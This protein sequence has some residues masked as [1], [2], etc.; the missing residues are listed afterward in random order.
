MN[1]V[2]DRDGKES[3]V[4]V[5]PEAVKADGKSIGRFGSYP[6]TEN[7]FLKV[8]SSSG[9]TVVSTAGL[10]LTN[11]QKIVTGQFS[12]DMLA[13]PVGIYDMTGEVAK[14]GVLTLMQFAAF[15]S[16]NLGIVNLLPIPALDGGR[17]LFLFV[18]AIR[19][20]PINREKEALVVFI[21]VAFLM[22]LMLVV[23]W[24]DIQRLFL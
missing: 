21:G 6:P 17:L 14:Q 20:K 2:I 24:N 19:G 16:I 1:V 12:L 23:T 9:T 7:G 13:G 10:I 15:L 18:E 22:L 3:T 4:Q 8:I 5:V 11:L